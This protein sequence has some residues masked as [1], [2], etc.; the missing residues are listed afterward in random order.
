M[1][2]S[3]TTSFKETAL[4]NESKYDD[5]ARVLDIPKEALEKKVIGVTSVVEDH[6]LV[7][8][9]YHQELVNH[10]STSRF[11]FTANEIRSIK[12][13][14]GIVVKMSTMKIKCQSFPHTSICVRNEVT[15]DGLFH[16]IDGRECIGETVA[17]YNT[18]KSWVPGT[19]VRVF[20]DDGVTFYSTHKTISFTNSRFGTSS[21][22]RDMWYADQ[23]A[24]TSDDEV[25]E[26][27]P[28]EYIVRIFI[29]KNIDLIVDSTETIAENNVY[30]IKSFSL[31]DNTVDEDEIARAFIEE[32]NKTASH[33]IKFADVLTVK[34][35]NDILNGGSSVRFEFKNDQNLSEIGHMLRNMKLKDAFEMLRPG[36]SVALENEY[37]VFRIMP[38][39][40]L[41]R[42]LMMDGKV[43]IAKLFADCIA[44]FAYP[45]RSK[46]IFIPTGFS[47]KQ[48]ESIKVALQ[49]EEYIDFDDFERL[50]VSDLEIVLTNLVFSCPRHRI[51]ECFDAYDNFGENVLNAA[52]FLW[53]E[54]K[55]L[56]DLIFAGK[57]DEFPGLKTWG[58][59][60]K[61]YLSANFC[62]CFITKAARGKKTLDDII[63][64]GKRSYWHYTVSKK[65]DEN[66]TIGKK[67]RDTT[68]LHRNAVLCL[69]VNAPGDVLFSLFSMKDKVLKA[70][71]AFTA[72]DA[73]LISDG[74]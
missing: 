6:D 9:H 13:V 67:T 68:Y 69:V 23:D 44:E 72:R 22:F 39:S 47:R 53:D 5:V 34:E 71:T 43:N 18:Y 73:R 19:L 26:D 57:I 40:A 7:S 52:A 55:R 15:D 74:R 61:K 12:K 41:T 59:S 21:T 70:R 30:Y 14:R 48:L 31:E 10:L 20:I 65:F 29:I 64:G 51:Q 25:F 37:G 24:F 1:S 8:F 49:N 28:K 45:E 60:L 3:K 62:A 42:N 38:P 58:V 11:G 16:L 63:D 54:Q 33:P 46:R 4:F 35:V 50:V 32:K 66:T 2:V 56:R 27:R 17:E 36:E